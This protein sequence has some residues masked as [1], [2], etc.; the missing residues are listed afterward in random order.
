[1]ADNGVVTIDANP[2]FYGTGQLGG[3][4]YDANGVLIHTWILTGGSVL[5]SQ[6]SGTV[7]LYDT[8][9]NNGTVIENGI[10][11]DSSINN[12]TITGDAYF[13]D[14]STNNGTVTGDAGFSE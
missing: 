3:D 10:F 13:T 2:T 1:V 8:S 7:Y 11:F 12:G 9:V 6:V 14:T 5:Q 4:V